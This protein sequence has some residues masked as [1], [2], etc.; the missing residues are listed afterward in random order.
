LEGGKEKSGEGGC[1]EAAG[2]PHPSGDALC[3][4]LLLRVFGNVVCVR[5]RERMWVYASVRVWETQTVMQIFDRWPFMPY[6]FIYLYLF[7]I[8]RKIVL[9]VSICIYIWITLKL[10]K[11]RKKE[12]TCTLKIMK[13]QLFSLVPHYPIFY[14]F[15]PLI[16]S[17]N[18]VEIASEQQRRGKRNLLYINWFLEWKLHRSHVVH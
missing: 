13:S 8:S 4:V 11:K 12:K 9:F 16:C 15:T 7:N 18:Y 10:K 5:E 6:I 3:L 1:T 2:K 17:I 14:Y